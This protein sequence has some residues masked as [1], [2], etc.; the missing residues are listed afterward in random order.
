M[1]KKS[2]VYLAV[3]TESII[4]V[5]LEESTQITC[6]IGETEHS[7]VRASQLKKKGE[8][9]DKYIE[10]RNDKALRRYIESCLR[11]YID[12]IEDTELFGNDHFRLSL[13]T[14]NLIRSQFTDLVNQAIKQAEELQRRLQ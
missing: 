11:Y 9:I 8:R 1:I 12:S 6:K 2:I 7:D 10:V 3:N 13:A 4:R 14:Y 5:A